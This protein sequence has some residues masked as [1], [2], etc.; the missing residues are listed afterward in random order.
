MTTLFV[1]KNNIFGRHAHLMGYECSRH[2]DIE[3]FNLHKYERL[4]LSAFSPLN[5]RGIADDRIVQYIVEAGY[6]G[7]ITYISS[8]RVGSVE[9]RYRHYSESKLRQ[10]NFLVNNLGR[11]VSIKRFPVVLG[12]T[13]DEDISGFPLLLKNGLKSGQVVFDVTAD[14]SWYF[15]FIDD[16][17]SRLFVEGHECIICPSPIKVSDFKE[18]FSTIVDVRLEATGIHSTYPLAAGFPYYISNKHETKTDT[19]KRILNAIS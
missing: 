3:K 8:M 9:E 4:I 18:F 19:M 16:I 2:N 1:G 10:E 15:V 13:P 5:K 12:C 7:A 14:S 17:F 6:Q 11:R